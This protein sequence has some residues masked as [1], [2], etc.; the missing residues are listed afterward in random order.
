MLPSLMRAT[1]KPGWMPRPPHRTNA[2]RGMDRPHISF[3]AAQPASRSGSCI[4]TNKFW[5]LAHVCSAAGRFMRAK[6]FYR[7]PLSATSTAIW[8]VCVCP[9]SAVAG[10]LCPTGSIRL[11]CWIRSRARRSL[12]WVVA[13]LR[14]TRHLWPIPNWISAISVRFGSVPVG[15]HHS[16]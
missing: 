13:P 11:Q 10:R 4:R 6:S 14:F 12:F 1:S 9:F 2:G 15:G 5:Q 8:R 3:P 16:P 7:S